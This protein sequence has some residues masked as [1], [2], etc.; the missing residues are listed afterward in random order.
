MFLKLG[1]RSVSMDDLS[2]E[3]GMSKKTLYQHVK[4]KRSLLH[5]VVTKHI[6]EEMQVMTDIKKTATDALD[7]IAQLAQYLMICL[8]DL[9]P[10]FNYDIQKFFPETWAMVLA[11]HDTYIRE[12]MI[13]NIHRGI[14]EGIYRS[15]IDP[16]ILSI[17][18]LSQTS[19]LVDNQR[20][21]PS[22]YNAQNIILQHLKYHLYG[23]ANQ[24][25]RDRLKG[26]K[27]FDQ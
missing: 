20:F 9:Q 7:E 1:V 3:L 5:L 14:T 26:V 19:A 22:R 12:V 23:I 24:R 13:Q 21:D 11:F 4:D 25:G 18:Y 17:L 8:K 16:E 6:E 27:L 10:A 15:D 2:R